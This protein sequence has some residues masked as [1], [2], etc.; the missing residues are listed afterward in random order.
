MNDWREILSW[1]VAYTET[2]NMFADELR[3][4][5]PEDIFGVFDRMV[6]YQDELIDQ[7]CAESSP[8]E[9]WLESGETIESLADFI[10]SEQHLQSVLRELEE[11]DPKYADPLE[12]LSMTVRYIVD[13]LKKYF[14]EHSV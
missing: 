9:Y 2:L 14:P 3:T 7:E 10:H 8:V 6:Q 11:P 5:L 13:T 12:N 1:R 4:R